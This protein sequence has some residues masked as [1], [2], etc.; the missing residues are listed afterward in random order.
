MRG[1]KTMDKQTVNEIRKEFPYLDEAKMGRKIVYLDNG[2]TS[3]KPQCVIDALANYYSY[4][5]ANPHRGAHYLGMLATDLYENSRVKVKNFIN[6]KSENE[7]I[8]VRNT[9]EALN[10]IAYSYGLDKLKAGD[11][12]VISV[13]EH[14][15][16]L[17]TWQFVA[18][19]TGAVL[20]YVYLNDKNELDMEGYKK[21]LSDNQAMQEAMQAQEA[22]AN[23]LTAS[24]L[25]DR[26]QSLLGGNHV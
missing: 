22:Q 1:V 18:Q 10:L 20:K 2:A 16:N 9:T 13:Y 6:A 4:Q 5:N 25:A 11:E 15:S 14:H 24:E 21:V 17:V 19:K 26:L 8:F 23:T 3:Q 7:I 12:I